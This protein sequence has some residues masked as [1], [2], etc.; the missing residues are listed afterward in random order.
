M[1]EDEILRDEKKGVKRVRECDKTE[2][3]G[4]EE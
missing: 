4:Q 1:C 2:R 3:K